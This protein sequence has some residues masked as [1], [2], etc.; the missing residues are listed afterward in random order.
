MAKVSADYEVVYILKPNLGEEENAALVEKFKT[1][2]ESHGTLKEVDEWGK[3]RLAYPINDMQ[4]GYYV[5]MAF[6]SAPA[7]P[8][9]LDRVFKITDG[10]MRSLIVCKDE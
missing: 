3:R 7:F 5:L 2:A 8:A 10:V 6:Q 4:E 9:E 1:L